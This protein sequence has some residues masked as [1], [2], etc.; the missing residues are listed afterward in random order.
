MLR[1]KLERKREAK[2]VP[3]TGIV[4]AKGKRV[5]AEACSVRPNDAEVTYAHGKV[6]VVWAMDKALGQKTTIQSELS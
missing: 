6:P 5:Q 2:K 3:C 1:S 4:E